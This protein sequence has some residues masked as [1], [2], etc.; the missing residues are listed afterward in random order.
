MTWKYTDD[1]YREY[2]RTTWNESAP[3]WSKYAGVLNPYR[4]DL[5]AAA[6]PKPGER[7][8][9]IATGAG[10]PAL[11][12]ARAVGPKGR[13]VGVDLSEELIAIAQRNA[14]E[15]R[16]ENAEF[17]VMDAESLTLPADSFD[18][19]VSA[20]GFQIIT[21]PEKAAQQAHRVLKPG[22]RIAL[23]VWGP[24]ERCQALHIMVGPMLEN[25]EPDETGYL[26]TPYEMGGPGE[27]VAFL[28]KA[29]FRGGRE[30]R[31]THDWTFQDAD[32]YFEMVLQG[33][34]LGH[35]L[36]EED[37]DVQEAV[38]RKTKANLQRWTKPDGRVAAPAECV[39]VTARK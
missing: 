24:A 28:E 9:D 29:G 38:L 13:V 39:V 2:T 22:G 33:T 31:F 30:Q 37:K 26:P 3:V 27:M 6:A 23:T 10:E 8:L 11:T 12:I 25:A 34:P 18:V 21:D 19:A 32:H 14:K 1:F 36:R 5:I 15:Q 7:V 35:S 16:A 17:H 20:F 4:G